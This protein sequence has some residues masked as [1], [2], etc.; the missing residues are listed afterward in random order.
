MRNFI[1]DSFTG[2]SEFESKGIK[3]AFKFGSALDVRKKVDSLSCQQAL[4]T[5]G[6]SA[7][8]DLINFIVPASDGNSY[9]FG[10]EGKIYKRTSGGTWTNVYTDEGPDRIE[11]AAEWFSNAGKSYLYWAVGSYL[12]RKEL[13]GLSNWTDVDA[14]AGWPK[15]TLTAGVSW[16]TMKPANGALMICNGQYLAM[17]GYDNSFTN[18]AVDLIGDNRSKTLIER[19]NSV[20]IG[21]R[22]SNS[23][24]DIQKGELFVWEQTALSWINKKQIP[25]NGINALIDTEFTLMQAGTNGDIYFSDLVNANAVK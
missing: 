24:T 10:D 22:K 4:V 14:D 19:G 21:T 16:H 6:A 1:I 20:V 5:E 12:H 18:N 17:V 13:P 11:G 9:A 15:T 7:I 8:T 25:A 23:Y 3:G 2:I